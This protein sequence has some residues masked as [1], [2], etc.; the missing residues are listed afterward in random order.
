MTRKT[1]YVLAAF[2]LFF[3]VGIFVV[4]GAKPSANQGNAAYDIINGH[5]KGKLICS[6][7][8][9]SLD[10][11][12]VTEGKSELSLGLGKRIDYD[13]YRLALIE[14]AFGGVSGF[15]GEW[16]DEKYPIDN[17]AQLKEYVR[18][19]KIRSMEE[20]LL[21]YDINPDDG[22]YG[23][24]YS[25]GDV[26]LWI[27][28][29]ENYLLSTKP[30]DRLYSKEELMNRVH[31]LAAALGATEYYD[32]QNPVELPGGFYFACTNIDGLPISAVTEDFLLDRDEEFYQLVGDGDRY[33]GFMVQ[34]DEP[35][36][37]V[38][39]TGWY[40]ITPIE[41]FAE[42][43]MII[44]AEEAI[45]SLAGSLETVYVDGNAPNLIKEELLIVEIR[46]AYAAIKSDGDEYSLRPVYMFLNAEGGFSFYVDAL[47]GQV[48]PKMTNTAIS[49]F[50][51][52]RGE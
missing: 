18:A 38:I 14:N 6:H 22:H 3:V 2:L 47:S 44:A 43:E 23:E 33:S 10:A 39:I 16:G 1:K 50:N 30:G 46:I 52:L 20:D 49:E 34:Q 19:Q 24:R 17:D 28:H 40:G 21:H 27:H 51:K 25:N 41:V 5:V 9:L 36:L 15:W 12:T 4:K 37:D 26:R 42:R 11:E 8:E 13:E 48:Y 45:E 32:F 31:E 7:F 29:R 35:S